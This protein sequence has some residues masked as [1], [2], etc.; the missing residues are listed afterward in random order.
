MAY[1]KLNLKDG[2]VVNEAHLRHIEEGI[3]AVDES[4]GDIEAALDSIL[5]IQNALI[6]G[7]GA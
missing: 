1:E 5:E 6:G 7:A 3:A 4:V 2:V